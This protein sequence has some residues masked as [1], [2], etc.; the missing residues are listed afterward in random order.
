MAMQYTDQAKLRTTTVL[1]D[2]TNSSP[3]I[4][5]LKCVWETVK[6]ERLCNSFNRWF[7]EKRKKGISFSYRFTGLESKRVSWNYGY[8]IKELLKIA[9]FSRGFA[10]KLHSLTFSG[11]QIRDAAAIYSRVEVS[12]RQVYNLKTL[13]QNYFSTNRLL[14]G[15]VSPSVW[16]LGYAIPYH[17]NQL[18]NKLGFGLGLNSMQGWEAKHIKLAKYI[19]NTYNVKKSMRWWIVFRHE[20]VCLIWLREMDPNSVSYWQEKKRGCDSYTSKRVTENDT[21]FCYCGLPKLNAGEEGC[22][23][24]TSS[25]MQ[26]V[27]QSVATGK[28]ITELQ[29]YFK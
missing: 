10:L 11:L 28:V 18:F 8:L 24:C 20:F 19:E 13:C 3:L 21:R 25:E 23:V 17:T 26:L 29:L 2:L 14:L 15:G 5:C 22:T 9:K 1:S 27:K 12:K 6:C 16:T 4:T 7:S